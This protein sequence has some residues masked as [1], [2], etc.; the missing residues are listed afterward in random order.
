MSYMD[1]FG[2]PNNQSIISDG[3]N[4]CH[5]S[6]LSLGGTS[7]PE[8]RRE[9]GISNAMF[10]K[11]RSKFGGMKELGDENRRLKK[12]NGRLPRKGD[13]AASRAVSAAS[14]IGHASDA[15]AISEVSHD[16]KQRVTR[17]TDGIWRSDGGWQSRSGSGNGR[18][19]GTAS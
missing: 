5:I 10:Y 1:S 7:A 17:S 19:L 11:W 9:Q 16:A 12:W 6:E 14:G 8:L 15:T 13:D 4:C 3:K 18:C 2:L